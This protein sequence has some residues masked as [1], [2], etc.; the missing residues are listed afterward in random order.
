[1]VLGTVVQLS[2][3]P[4]WVIHPQQAPGARPPSQG[5]PGL[6]PLLPAR[7]CHRAQPG[8]LGPREEGLVLI[9]ASAGRFPWWPSPR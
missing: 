7:S 3:P 2:P 5:I 1:M 9:E 6:T 4:G 8:V